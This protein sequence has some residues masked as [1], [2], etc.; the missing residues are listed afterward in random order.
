[1]ITPLFSTRHILTGS[2][3]AALAA[4]FFGSST[5]QAVT[6]YWDG[7]NNT[8]GFGTAGGTWGAPT[9]GTATAAWNQD[10]GGAGA[11]TLV[12]VSV[13][14]GTGDTLNFGTAT[15]LGTGTI[16]VGTVSAGN[17]VFGSA[18]GAITLS[19]GTINLGASSITVNNTSDT[20][21]SLI[22]GTTNT[23]SKAGAGTLILTNGSTTRTGTLTISGGTVQLGNGTA[24]GSFLNTMPIVVTSATL[25]FKQTDTVTQGTDFST[26]AV[27]GTGGITQSGTGTLV[28]NAN[29]TYT[30]ATTV[31]AGTLNI[32]NR[33]TASGGITVG[34]ASGG[35]AVLGLG[36]GNSFSLG[37]SSF[38][39]GNTG[40]NGTVNHTAGAI[41]F[42]GGN[43]LLIGNST[44]TGTYNLSG[45]TLS[46][47]A[48]S[49]GV[50]VGVNTGTTG[51]FNLSGTGT[52]TMPATSTLQITRSDNS[53]ATGA[54]GTFTQTGGTATVGFL[55]MGGSSTTPANNANQ[56]ATLSLTGGTFSAVTFNQLSG[57][58]GST[59]AINIGGTAQVTLPKFTGTRNG[60]ATITFDSSAGGYLRPTATNAAY[61]PANTYTSANLTANG[62]KIDTNSFDITI[63][64]VLQNAPSASG[65]L[66]KLGNGTLTLTG[67]NTY[68][69]GT[70]VSAGTLLLSGAVNMPATGALQVNTGATFSLA[71]G[72]A[73]ATTTAASLNLANGSSL[74]FDWVAGATDTLTSS[75]AATATGAVGININPLSAPAGSGLT[76][77]SSS[78]GGLTSGGANYFLANNTNYSATLTQS[79]TA[80][81]ISSYATATALTSAYWLGGQVAG[82]PG[83]MALSNNGVSNWASDAAGTSAG[84][85]VPGATADVFFST[86]AG[87]TQQANVVLGSNMTLN[88]VTF[89]DTTPVTIGADGT[90][91]TLI[92]TSTGAASA[93]SANQN[94]TINARVV[95]GAAQTWSVANATTLNVGGVVSGAFGLTKDG[96]GTLSMTGVNTYSGNTAIAAGLLTIDGAGQMGSG[97]YAGTI[98]N[99]GT[100][101]YNSSAA[102][103]LSGVI[104]GAG[105]I[106]KSG[107]GTLTLSGANAYTG[108][109]TNSAG[110]LKLG[111]A[112]ALGA[113]TGAS[114][115]TTIS[116]GA[117]LDLGGVSN[118]QNSSVGAERI[119]VSGAGVG[120]NGAIISSTGIATPFIGVRY[121]TL[122]G[123]TT[124]GFSNR[125]DVGSTTAANN[126]FV[127]GGFNLT[128]LGTAAAAQASLNF[129]GATDL[130]DISVNLG[131]VTAT[132]ILFLQG[133]TTLGQAAKTVTI[134]GG[135]TLNIFTNSTVTNFDKKFALDNGNI[136]VQKTGGTS[137]DGTISLA[138]A[139]TITASTATA[140]TNEISGNGSLTKTGTGTLTFSGTSN[141]T[142]MGLTSVVKTSATGS[143]ILAKT[144]GAL[145]IAGDLTIGDGTATPGSVAL[146]GNN[147]IN[148]ASTVT[149]NGIN[150]GWG[151]LQMQG[152]NQTIGTVV[153]TNPGFGVIETREAAGAFGTSSITFN[154][155]SGTQSYQGYFR[156]INT[157]IDTA[158]SL[159]LVKTGSGTLRFGAASNG[160]GSA[161]T[162]GTSHNY[163]G[164]TTIANGTLQLTTATGT[165]TALSIV[166]TNG[167]TIDGG[168]TFAGTLD[169]NGVNASMTGLNGVTGTVLGQVVNNA[170]N[171][172]TLTIGSN[173]TSGSFAGQIK[174]NNNAGTGVLALTKTGTGTQTLSGTNTY[175]GATTV[176]GGMLVVALGTGGNNVLPSGSAL[177]LGGS[178]LQLTGTGTQTV[179]GLTTTPNTANRILLGASQTLTLGGLSFAGS[180]SVLNFNTAAG[181]ANAT[182]TTI[183][184]S[185]IFLTG[186]TPGN[187]INSGFTVTDTGGFGL[188]T[189]N[190]SDQVVRSTA[191]NLLP[192]SGAVSTI[193]YLIDNNA[194]GSAAPGSSSLVVTSSQ[195]TNSITVDTSATVGALTLNSGVVMSNDTW[196]FGG[197]GSNTFNITGSAGGAGLSSVA[198][199]SAITVNNFNAA[200]VTFTSPILA[201][202]VN[203]VFVNGPGTTVFAGTNT[204]TGSTTINVGTLQLGDGTADGTIDNSTSVLNNGNLSFNRV[205]TF[206]SSVPISG[207]GA[208]IKSGAG[209]QILTG[210]NT[211]TGGTTI[212]ASSGTLQATITQTTSGL[213]TGPVSV[214]SGSTLLLNDT[215]I[216]N[217]ANV[218]LINNVFS[219]TGVINLQFAANTTARNTYMPNVAGFSGTIQLSALG[220]TGDKWNAANLG[221]VAG[222]LIIDSGTT[223]LPSGTASF[224]GG[225]TLNG[226]GN[227][228]G[229]GAIRLQGILGGNINLAS[230][231]TINI[232]NAAALLTGNISSGAAGTQILTLG[233]TGSTG[234][235]LSGII[236]GGTGTLD[237]TTAVG[238]TYTLTNANTYT[239]ATTIAASTTLQLGN[240]TNGN[241]GTIASTSGITD[242]GTLVYNRFGTLSSS[243]PISGTGAV[244]KTG[245]GTQI[246]A[247]NNTYAGTT[248]VTDGTLILSGDN[249]AASGVTNISGG[250]L[251]A[252]HV[253]ALNAIGAVA[254]STTTASGTLR[255]ATDT[256]V[257]AFPLT[258]ST[259]N[260]GTIISDRATLGAGI[261]H[262]LGAATL[263]SNI[264]TVAAGGNVTS[265]T[266]AISI[267]SV[268]LSSG[269]AGTSTFNPTT[270]NVLIPGAVNIGGNSALKTLGLSGLSTGNE[271][272]GDIS[273]GL[274]TLSVTKSLTSTWTLSG[275]NTYTGNTTV[276]G[277][278]LNLTGTLT[279]NT[280]SSTLAYGG[281]AANSVVNVG[282]NMTLFTTTAATVANANA[283][284]N[285]TAGIV[286]LSPTGQAFNSTN[287]YGYFNLTGGTVKVNSGNFLLTNGA[288]ATGVA[289]VGGTGILDLN[290][291]ATSNGGVTFAGSGT[292][293]V[294]PGGTVLRT[295]GAAAFYLT[296]FANATGTLNV[297]GGNIDL[298]T[299]LLR[300]GNGAAIAGINGFV[301]LASGTL[302]MGAN[303]TNSASGAN[304]YANFAG[305][306]LKASAALNS[307]FSTGGGVTTISTIFGPINNSAAVGNASQ[308]F[309]GGLTVDT[310]GNSVTYGNPLRGATG[311]GVTQGN[312]TVTGGSGYIGAPAVTFTGGTLA[313]NGT[314]ASGYALVSGGAVTGI[315]ITSPGEYTVA[316][317]VSLAGGGGTGAS[318]AVG[319][320][321]AN[322]AD[323]GLTKI[324]SGTLTLTAT[325]TYTGATNVNAGTLVFGVSETLSALN[326][327]DGAVVV[328]GSALPAPAPD[329]GETASFFAGRESTGADFSV[330]GGGSTVAAVPEPGSMGLLLGGA[331]AL[332]GVRRRRQ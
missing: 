222:N 83:A 324:G 305:G 31:A 168:A 130:G 190:G 286:N 309:A 298:G 162:G 180:G 16:T 278:T 49:L 94:A 204:Y 177:T 195:S 47:V 39:V 294:G 129:L 257:N 299:G 201:N 200:Q 218:P 159:A 319:G 245:P 137:L 288:A 114:D 80:V 34:V 261:T 311:S 191:T 151:Y 210:A 224:A 231:S 163:T 174:D 88:S 158:N 207:T 250:I 8:A 53:A 295:S 157:G 123:D 152:Q 54:T 141:N 282:N 3:A 84:G 167:V 238:G 262:F 89:N 21:T 296:A 232:D 119:T 293:T 144:G 239:G 279:G 226:T 313:T 323:T 277:G 303:F 155:A 264:W 73:S 18:S 41:S 105:A 125:W 134:T 276:S 198:S 329:G 5:A 229:R 149:F 62:A 233:A 111:N 217:V 2:I 153:E 254:I 246:L 304:L 68:T 108:L 251:V 91:L 166:G 25:A 273:N 328:L 332:L 208:V 142:Y 124:L 17:M 318:V 120:G 183:G 292:L 12:G 115:G 270:A 247:G 285:Q 230:S 310:N 249:S 37:T 194:G 36:T 19:G 280:T 110:T 81:Q 271:I 267:A 35:N 216:T 150:G 219:G 237:L 72:T 268:N 260:P 61:M 56:N 29:N 317:A 266:A 181:G 112:A 205:G 300:M 186:Q 133:D 258:S 179:N 283:I 331:L 291:T 206:S 122:A 243:L 252:A 312:M 118:G 63:G 290:S 20:I 326:I 213:G 55:Q 10:S 154:V 228:E 203:P 143:L 77:I 146:G 127:G 269:S 248:T 165:S 321:T 42:T 69:G 135:S 138:N 259:N 132:N 215:S 45:G 70:I 26:A 256:S 164:G 15:G 145:A 197:V 314:P 202:G 22:G 82:G 175:T 50:T 176:N 32:T 244:T 185:V 182:T 289:Y 263:G 187:A 161:G 44:G 113:G 306:T 4:A 240:G 281:T 107:A 121:L 320:L 315:V 43:Q 40:G 169:L 75:T 52:L 302:T 128:F 27:T 30:G 140:V 67:A 301:N 178:T 308:N 212:N 98:S 59:S 87:A 316:P 211:Y 193:D 74:A 101:T 66:T 188:A 79:D 274:N 148:P 170:S 116:A 172:V 99:A 104:S 97:N 64:Q 23:W 117:T 103:T 85:V 236:G 136:V 92:S 234:G 199:G 189:V 325:N 38:F 1:M 327:A 223:L 58:T 253:D 214:G 297:A 11:S 78:A 139:N 209:T 71:D 13:T 192:A 227:A 156:D 196:N 65:T 171:S 330:E 95:L 57:G 287:G 28:L 6:Y 242:N 46:T 76:L 100:L 109:T 131:A 48:S 106:N 7:N 221:T 102:Q 322:A 86:T 284:Y 160:T 307:P 90:S 255:L 184:T 33:T 235:T 126:G 147:Q 225:I 51:N 265:G 272:S 9:V 96:P 220:I 93:I 173:N 241:D 275:T 24:T 14:T 60:A